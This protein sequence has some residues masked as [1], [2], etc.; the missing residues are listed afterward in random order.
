MIHRIPKIAINADEI[1][2]RL[3]IEQEPSVRQALLLT[4]GSGTRWTAV[5]KD[6]SDFIENLPNSTATTPMRVVIQRLGGCC[7][8]WG[9]SKEADRIDLDLAKEGIRKDRNWYVTPHGHSMLIVRGPVNSSWATIHK[10]S[11]V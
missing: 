10:T 4:L 2:E 3:S 5:L 1:V 11:T 9:L 7:S 8:N 6:N